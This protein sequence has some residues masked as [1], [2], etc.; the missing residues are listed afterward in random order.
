MEAQRF[1]PKGRFVVEHLDKDGILKDVYEF[2]NG[3]TD[4]GL[5][6]ILDVQFGGG[7]QTGTWYI[8]LI[9][10][11]GFS[12]LAAGDTLSSHNG[13]SEFTSYTEANRVEWDDDAAATRSKTNSSTANFSINA[14]GNVYGIFVSSNNVKSTGNTGILWSTAAFS[15]V[16][17]T[18]NGDTL[19]VTYTVSG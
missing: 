6:D 3:I 11:S 17:A 7:S 16:V 13:W 5:N 15:S 9:D 12:A 10:N 1:Q 4:E 8:G 19:K 18:A 14:T 2:P